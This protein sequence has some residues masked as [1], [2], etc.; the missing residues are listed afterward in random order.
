[1]RNSRLLQAD[2]SRSLRNW[3]LTAGLMLFAGVLYSLHLRRPLDSS[4]AY[5]ALAAGQSSSAAVIHIAMRFDPGKPPLYQLMLHDLVLVFGNHEII[6]RSLSVIFSLMT[7]ALLVALGAEIFSFEIGLSAAAIWALSPLAILY[8]SWARNYAMLLALLTGQLFLLWR[9]RR[10]ASI[11]GVL[12]CVLAA[13]TALYTHLASAL[14]LGAE[15]AMLA[16]DFWRGR[17]SG[18]AWLALLISAVLF[19]PFI[20]F[21]LGQLSELVTNHWVDWIGFAHQGSAGGK[22]AALIGAGVLVGILV[23]GSPLEREDE[24][25]LRWCAA[26]AILPPALL[27]AGSIAVRPMFAIRYVSPS[28]VILVLLL[29]RLLASFGDRV[30]RLSTVGIAAFFVFLYPCYGWYEPWRDIAHAISSASPEEPVFFEPIFT[31]PRDPLADHGQGF[32]QGFLRAAFDYYYAGPNPRRVVDPAKPEVTRRIIA[33]AATAAH[34]AWLLTT[35]DE[36]TARA[37]LPTSCF[38]IRKMA[39]GHDATLIHVIPLPLDVCA[40]DQR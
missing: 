21:A 30:F 22:A 26:I 3:L 14:F 37:E 16:R 25:P 36:Q 13:T 5:T 39:Q 17:R 34:G 19:T 35:S 20:P 28:V 31:D 38:Q 1:M 10:R 7:V 27:L 23:A 12:M 6:M 33:Q 24:E 9:L 40:R 15:A 18:G 2:Q 8:G 29:A 32:P 4:E 11:G